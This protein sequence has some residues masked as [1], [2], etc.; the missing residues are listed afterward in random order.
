MIQ[1]S[2]LSLYSSDEEYKESIKCLFCKEHTNKGFAVCRD[3]M[4]IKPNFE[5]EKNWAH[6]ECYIGWFIEE[7]I[8]E[9][10]GKYGDS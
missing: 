2:G 8:K 5:M 6:L 1:D 7:K 3:F 4:K 9:E 10:M